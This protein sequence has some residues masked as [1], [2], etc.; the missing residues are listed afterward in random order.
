MA[1]ATG[2]LV[3]YK[4]TDKGIAILTLNRPDRYNAFTMEMIHEWLGRLDEAQ[5][6]PE[7]RALILT[8]A[9]K[10]FCAGGDAG[11]MSERAGNNDPLEQKNFLWR[12][13]HQVALTLE[14]LDKPMLAAINGVARG[15]GLDMA[16]MCDIRIMDETANVAE[17]YINMGLI[18]G[19][20][21][22]W[23]LPRLVG[24]D[25]ALEL[26]WSS[27]PVNAEEALR[28][29]MVTEVAPEG[30]S[31]ARAIEMAETFVTQPPEA[32]RMYKRAVYQG[33]NMPLETHLDMLSSHLAVLRGTAEHRER[34]A[35]FL[36][37]KKNA[38]DK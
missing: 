28:I 13:V 33:R 3:L 1:E 17:S 31:L 11:R 15:A 5:A 29:G 22:T 8:G 21:G 7:V 19:D 16:L 27:R 37:R 32:V 23:Y 9:G 2:D 34:V 18:A 6:D 38:A 25:R 30:Q 35:A 4:V 20:G 14:R 12:H 24:I 26:M 10:A 36:A